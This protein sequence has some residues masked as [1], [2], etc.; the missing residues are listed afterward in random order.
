M[1]Y[2]LIHDRLNVDVSRYFLTD[3][4]NLSR[5]RSKDKGIL[6]TG[7]IFRR[8]H[9]KT[10]YTNRVLN[11]WKSL[12]VNIRSILPPKMGKESQQLLKMHC[13]SGTFTSFDTNN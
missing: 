9:C 4:V 6:F 13:I 8:E 11:L 3:N 12:P 7:A 10:Y 1:Y 5:G 2:N